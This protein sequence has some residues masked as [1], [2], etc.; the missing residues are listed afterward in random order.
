ML[1]F[2]DITISFLCKV[3]FC[4]KSE[5]YS[6]IFIRQILYYYFLYGLACITWKLV[7]SN[8]SILQFVV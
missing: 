3:K 5:K 2:I 4:G 1:K 7:E 6:T 8:L